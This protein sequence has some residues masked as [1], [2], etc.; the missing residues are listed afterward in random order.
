MSNNFHIEGNVLGENGQLKLPS[1][2]RSYLS[3]LEFLSSVSSEKDY[4]SI[5]SEYL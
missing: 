5:D 1:F 3:I 2:Q 4:M